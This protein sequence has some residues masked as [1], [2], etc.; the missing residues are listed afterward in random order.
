MPR[1]SF[2]SGHLQMHTFGSGG[3]GTIMAITPTSKKKRANVGSR[4]QMNLG[5]YVSMSCRKMYSM[6]FVFY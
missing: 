2:Y 3:D 5:I 1:K 6:Y 4:C